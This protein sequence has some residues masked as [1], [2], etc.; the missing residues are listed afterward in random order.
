MNIVRV[1]V[2]VRGIFA[3]T[4]TLELKLHSSFLSYSQ[5]ESAM[6]AVLNVQGQ[7]Y[8]TA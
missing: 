1:R 3:S 7:K 8:T 4:C 5:F 2:R 6:K